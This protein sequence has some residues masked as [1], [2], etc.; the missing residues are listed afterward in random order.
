MNKIQEI[1][2]KSIDELVV[3][4]SA[5]QKSKQEKALVNHGYISSLILK[6]R[7]LANQNDIDRFS[8]ATTEMVRFHKEPRLK[9]KNLITN[10][11]TALECKYSFKLPRLIGKRCSCFF[12][13]PFILFSVG[14][15]WR[16]IYQ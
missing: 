13:F 16:R 8:K 3:I 1:K 10:R 12:Q 4:K 15:N 7:L 6:K 14:F 2:Q 5:T 9:Q 11:S